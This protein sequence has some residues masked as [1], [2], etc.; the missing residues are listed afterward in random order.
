MGLLGLGGGLDFPISPQIA[1]KLL[2]IHTT[3]SIL[4]SVVGKRVWEEIRHGPGLYGASGRKQ[5][6]DLPPLTDL[7]LTR[8]PA[9]GSQSGEAHSQ[10]GEL[11]SLG[12][13]SELRDHSVEVPGSKGSSLMEEACPGPALSCPEEDLAS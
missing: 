4:G 7:T 12:S 1:S 10:F 11:W 9:P 3:S 8:P 5:L 13:N 6:E 2:W